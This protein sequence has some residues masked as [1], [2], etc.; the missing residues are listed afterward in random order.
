[1]L[2]GK[3]FPSRTL[4]ALTCLNLVSGSGRN[5]PT[6]KSINSRSA[7]EA[8]THQDHVEPPTLANRTASTSP[9]DNESATPNQTRARACHEGRKG[10]STTATHVASWWTTRV[11]GSRNPAEGRVSDHMLR[12]WPR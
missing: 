11:E 7:Y 9:A 6:N 4:T 10:S 1:M 8:P 5:I 12:A 3:P 2:T